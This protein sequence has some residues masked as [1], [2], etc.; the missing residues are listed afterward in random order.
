MAGSSS[1]AFLSRAALTTV[2]SLSILAAVSSSAL[3]EVAVAA[4]HSVSL[5]TLSSVDQT[6]HADGDI[7]ITVIEQ[8]RGGSILITKTK[9]YPNFN[10]LNTRSRCNTLKLPATRVDY[11]SIGNYLGLD[12]VTVEAVYPDGAVKRI[13][14]AVSVRP[15][16]PGATPDQPAPHADAAPVAPKPNPPKPHVRH[17]E[18]HM[19]PPTQR[20]CPAPCTGKTPSPTSKPGDPKP[21]LTPI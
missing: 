10:V 14:V 5:M 9:A 15:V 18:A 2:V 12:Y 8:P 3:A 20:N 16:A 21:L 19:R 11:Q 13:R 4:G 7:A 17:A 6:C 1:V